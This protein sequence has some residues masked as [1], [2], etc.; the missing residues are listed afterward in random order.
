MIRDWQSR[1]RRLESYR[2]D[3]WEFVEEENDVKIKSI[4]LG[5]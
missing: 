3:Y 4:K 2:D 1:E 5:E